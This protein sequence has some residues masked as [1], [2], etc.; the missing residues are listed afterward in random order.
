VA[1]APETPPTPEVRNEAAGEQAAPAVVEPLA[2]E[3][4]ESTDKPVQ[5]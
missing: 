5:P 2:Q 1:V 4:P 3:G